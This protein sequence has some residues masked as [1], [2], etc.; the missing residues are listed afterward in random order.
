M[1]IHFYMLFFCVVQLFDMIYPVYSRLCT[2]CCV[3]SGCCGK[4]DSSGGRS[5]VLT[6]VVKS[7]YLLFTNF[8][9]L[10]RS[11]DLLSR[12]KTAA[13]VT[14]IQRTILSVVSTGID[15][16]QLNQHYII[17]Q[18]KTNLI[19]A[20]NNNLIIHS[21]ILVKTKAEKK[22]IYSHININ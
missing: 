3:P 14:K 21:L 18:K 17:F 12:D 22:C 15:Q 1:K 13:G 5:K 19:H 20:P 16:I 8:F 11:R 4:I 9:I 10:T 7:C 2:V 6:W